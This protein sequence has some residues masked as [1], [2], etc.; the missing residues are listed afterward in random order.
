[1]NQGAIFRHKYYT[2]KKECS[3]I[4]KKFITWLKIVMGI[5]L[6]TAVLVTPI[7]ALG[8]TINTLMLVVG[9]HRAEAQVTTI[10]PIKVSATSVN[11]QTTVAFIDRR[12]N[13]IE[14]TINDV[15][16]PVYEVGERLPIIYQEGTRRVGPVVRVDD[17]W[18]I[19]K[20]A[21]IAIG[22]AL[23]SV[24]IAYLLLKKRALDYDRSSEKVV[25]KQRRKQSKRQQQRQNRL[26]ND[27]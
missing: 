26:Q 20:D 16:A 14:R 24:G 6:A 4:M 1:L 12:G 3:K 7:I 27:L 2:N 11:Y 8:F 17:F 21:L 18:T 9:G 5:A 25:K 22:I 23:S 10:V 15:T 13:R 19:W